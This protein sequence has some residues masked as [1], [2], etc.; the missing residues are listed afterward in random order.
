MFYHQN[1]IEVELVERA[2]YLYKQSDKKLVWIN[3][4]SKRDEGEVHLRRGQEGPE[5][6]KRY[7]STLPLTSALD[8][9]SSLRHTPTALPVG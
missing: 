4:L 5:G 9:E 6:E 3:K 2:S 1:L 7:G 8:G